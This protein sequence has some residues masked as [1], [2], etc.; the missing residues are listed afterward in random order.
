[1]A[2][3][4]VSK[5]TAGDKPNFKFLDPDNV[6]GSTAA[7][8][9]PAGAQ[10]VGWVND[11]DTGSGPIT[12]VDNLV[13]G[14]GYTEATVTI[15]GNGIGATAEAVIEEGVITEI[16]I[17]NGGVSYT[18]ATITIEGQDGFDG[19]PASADAV[20]TNRA[21]KETIVAFGSMTA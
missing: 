17:T 4:G 13:G 15:T 11:V 10:H 20:I 19:D 12:D 14:T 8:G 2:N 7:D 5:G 18:E 1:M 16:N 3:W 21:K 6:S 9:K